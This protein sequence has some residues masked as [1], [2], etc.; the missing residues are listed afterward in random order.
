[1]SLNVIPPIVVFNNV[2]LSVNQTSAPIQVQF[3]DNIAIQFVWTGT[4]VGLFGVNVS[5]TATLNAVGVIT[6][7]SWTPMILTY[8]NIP[9]TI[10]MDG[11]GT[12]ELT[13]ICSSFIQIVYTATSGAGRCTATLTAKPV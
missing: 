8:P 9:Q 11:N 2:D 5:T 1:M 4:P 6:G 7:G 3:S 13:Q 12:I 10:G